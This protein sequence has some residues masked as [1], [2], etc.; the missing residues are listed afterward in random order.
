MVRIDNNL[1]RPV[2]TIV[3]VFI[4]LADGRR[5]SAR[6]WLPTDAESHPVPALLELHPYGAHGPRAVGD[7]SRHAYLAG[8]GY[9][10]ARVDLAGFGESDGEFDDEYL[11]SE[12]SDAE[13]VIA[14]LAEQPWCSGSVGM[15]GISWGGFNTLAV[16]A[17]QPPALRAVVSAC[18]SDDRYADDVHYF[19]GCVIGQEMLS[20]STTMLA[21]SV[22]PPD[23][24]L[25]GEEHGRDL[26]NQ[27]I[28]S[29]HPLAETW[30]T[31]QRRDEYWRQSSLRD[32]PGSIRVPV[33]LIGG[34]ADG[35]RDGALRLLASLPE[36]ANAHAIIGP[37]GHAWPDQAIPGPEIGVLDEMLRWWD[38]WLKGA[39]TGVRQDPRLRAWLQEPVR[40]AVHYDSRPGHWVGLESWPSTQ[41]GELKF[42]LF[43]GGLGKSS[44]GY[45]VD[46]ADR[47]VLAHRGRL[48]PASEAGPWCAAGRDA[49]FP[50]DQQ[51]EDGQSLAFTSA[52]LDDAI[53]ILGQP[54]LRLRVEADQPVAQ[55]A[56]RL[57]DVWPDGASTL[58]CRGVRN[59]THRSDRSE[60]VALRPDVPI[61]LVAELQATSYRMLPGHR[62]R[63][64]VSTSL[65]PLAWPA[66]APVTLKIHTDS[67]DLVVP[68]F[69]TTPAPLRTP[70]A[71]EPV[72]APS[73]EFEMVSRLG[74]QDRTAEAVTTRWPATG[75]MEIRV[76]RQGPE[77]RLPDGTT[78]HSSGHDTFSIVEHAPTSAEAISVRVLETTSPGNE[79]VSCRIVAQG[80]MTCTEGEWLLEHS[81]EVSEGSVTVTTRHWDARVTRDHG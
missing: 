33:L 51:A 76:P 8:H 28:A 24:R 31:H 50:D 77:I 72:R 68:V 43:A 78:A 40:P 32:D 34:W 47:P 14:W 13:E 19:G 49:D 21:L 56:I 53:I 35:Y 75:R 62:L 20:W 48:V 44:Q 25:T 9:A 16:A 45:S 4:P 52:P 5:L 2:R 42:A 67:S 66:P 81:L 30:L 46:K 12:L 65:W 70:L 80:R 74:E 71:P 7:P 61:D 11:P 57:C 10:C 73:E 15:F 59:L 1:P 3:S 26:W 23:F 18:A 55:V 29:A 58:I 22:C 69:A 39:D 38:Q 41:V 79:S 37:W 64:S 63:I 60:P 27:R 6:L 17:R 54:T 36:A